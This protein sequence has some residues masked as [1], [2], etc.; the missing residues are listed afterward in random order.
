VSAKHFSP[1][2]SQEA[3]SSAPRAPAGS[4][5]IEILEDGDTVVLTLGRGV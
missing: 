4:L 2:Q 1:K 3:S 5:F